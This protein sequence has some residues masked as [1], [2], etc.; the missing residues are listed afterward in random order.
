MK[1]GSPEWLA[2][3]AQEGARLG[4]LGKMCSGCAFNPN[5]PHDR[6]YLVAVQDATFQLAW[7]GRFHCHTADH[8]DAGTPCIGFLYASRCR[9][10][11]RR[12]GKECW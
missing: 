7:A 2:Q 4:N 1:M 10:E 9:S 12:V 6:D 5:Q 11:V 3:L 8:K